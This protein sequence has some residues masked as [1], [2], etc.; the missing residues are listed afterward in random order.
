MFLDVLFQKLEITQVPLCRRIVIKI[1]IYKKMEFDTAT[2]NASGDI[3]EQLIWK[4]LNTFFFLL[5]CF[6]SVKF[7]SLLKECV[8]VCQRKCQT[9]QNG[10]LTE[11]KK[12]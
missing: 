2:K 6:F 5:Y 11:V 1:M 7:L 4:N 12:E 9:S 10:K 3:E 8:L